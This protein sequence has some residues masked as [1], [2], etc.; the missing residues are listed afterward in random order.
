MSV[1]TQHPEAPP[2]D[3][4]AM[5]DPAWLS[6]ALGA[7]VSSV[8]GTRVGTGQMGQSWRLAIELADGS[9]RALV[10]KMAG[11]DPSTRTLIADGYRN[12]FTY[13]TEVRDTLAIRS[14]RCWYATITDDNTDFVLLL[15]DLSPAVPGEQVRGVDAVE[16]DLAIRNLAGLHGPRW[17]DPTLE[18]VTG[19]R[20]P[21]PEGAGFHAQILAG[22]IPMFMERFGA[23][24]GPDD[25]PVL[26]R[27]PE[28]LVEWSLSRADRRTLVHGD[29]R[30]D[31]LM[32]L[33]DGS[34]VTAL[35]WQT[36]G[37]GWGGRDVGYFL[38]LGLPTE[39]R[40]ESERA[41]V[42][43]YHEALL[44]HGVVDHSLDTCFDDYRAGTLQ[45]PLVTVLGAVYATAEPTDA[46]NAMF[47][48]MITRSCAAIRELDAFSAI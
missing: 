37:L 13:Y 19:M 39:V 7:P 12:E 20:A 18:S 47:A 26:E 43:A 4:V 27:I 24:M 44:G 45:G 8:N 21:E 48:S 2:T 5:L 11:G 40:R 29:Y 41:L 16:A 28:V 35:D 32:Y 17:N 6:A 10:A 36:L 3:Q 23:W 34:I 31:N 15:D 30:P 14:P 22:A 25:L 42:A 33:P 1:P 38:G 46:S 9:A